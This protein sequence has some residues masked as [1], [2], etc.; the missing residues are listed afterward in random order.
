MR[1]G[2]VRRSALV[3]AVVLMVAGLFLGATSVSAQEAAQDAGPGIVPVIQVSGLLDPVLADY[4]TEAIERGNRDGATVIV[5]QIDSHGSVL[6]QDRL[7]ELAETIV[8]SDAPVT[9]WVGPSRA[10]ALGAVAQLV[11]LSE[12]V[13]VAPGARLGETGPQVLS[14][15]KYGTIWGDNAALLSDRTLNHEQVIEAGIAPQA[16]AIVGE[17]VLT[18]ADFGVEAVAVDNGT[19]IAQTVRFERLGIVEQQLHTVA[20]PPVAYLLFITGLGLFIF[21]FFTAGVG[22]A[23][24]IGAGCFLLGTYGLGVLPT[25]TWAIVVLV[26]AM[27][28]FA[29]DVQT[30]IPRFW[31]GVGVV[32]FIIGSIWLYDGVSMSWITLLVGIGS[33]LVAMITGMPT[34]VR[35]RFSTPTIGRDWMVG[36]AGTAV[37]AVA[38]DGVVK[39]R[40]ALW[41]ARTNR[42]TPVTIGDEIR[43]V[44]IDG[45]VL[46]VEPATGGAK[47][48]RER[49]SQ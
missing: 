32:L 40:D 4:L 15:E 3:A 36:E 37:E 39:I 46:E 12:R 19:Q 18:L 25:R 33:M 38:P 6:D 35:T 2:G 14:T 34:M 7:D 28:A 29:I 16:A 44:A 21:E 22:V 27:L 23:G 26:L 49:D 24:I 48:Y 41:R 11:G 42:A 47:D 9:A 43:V 10:R 1:T 8:N 5:L 20:S 30:G 45:L 31:T 13:G 17:F